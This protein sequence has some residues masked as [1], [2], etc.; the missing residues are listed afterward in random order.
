MA[1]SMADYLEGK[2]LDHVLGGGDFT[3]PASVYVGILTTAPTDSGGG[4]E[5][6]G[7]AYA[8]VALTNNATNWP[9]SSGTNPTIKANG[10][11]VTFP[12]AT[13]AWGTVQ[14]FGIFDASTSGNLLFWGT[15]T[16]PKV[17]AIDDTPSFGVGALTITQD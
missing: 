7:G 15:L 9:A 10:T 11:A 16:T 12:R 5:V 3:R 2:I 13:A 17:V 14:A 4:V 8:R 6:S 1:G